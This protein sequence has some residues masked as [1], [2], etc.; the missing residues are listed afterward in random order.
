M[1]ADVLRAINVQINS[2][3]SAWYQYLAMAA[4]CERE[5][6]TGAANWLIGSS[7]HRTLSPRPFGSGPMLEEGIVDSHEKPV[8]PQSLYLAQLRDRLGSEALKNIGYDSPDDIK[9]DQAP[10]APRAEADAKIDPMLG[11]DLAQNR[12]V[13]TATSAH[14]GRSATA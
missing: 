9:P 3:F 13:S 1:H 11:A 4:F 8:K 5:Q 10:V 12:P 7:G 6:F 2:E 14:T